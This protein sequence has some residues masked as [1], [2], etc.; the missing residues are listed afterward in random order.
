[1]VAL[2]NL[3]TLIMRLSVDLIDAFFDD[4]FR[5]IHGFRGSIPLGKLHACC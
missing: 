4:V 5:L 1:M 2:L 3:E